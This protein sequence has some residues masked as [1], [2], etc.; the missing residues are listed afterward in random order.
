MG[1]A[2]IAT[3]LLLLTPGIHG[4]I[5]EYWTVTNTACAVGKG[6]TNYISGYVKYEV[7]AVTCRNACSSYAWCS[8]IRVTTVGHIQCMLL[9][10]SPLS[11]GGGGRG[12]GA[13]RGRVCVIFLF[14]V[15]GTLDR[16]KR[17]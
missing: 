11:G 16:V 14:G 7:D 15:G 6:G 5:I 10:E 1:S 12:G 8:G 3:V 9:T 2:F 4:C 17:R 13:G